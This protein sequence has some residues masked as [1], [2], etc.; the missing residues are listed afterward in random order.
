MRS[1]RGLPLSPGTPVSNTIR[2]SKFATRGPQC[3]SIPTFSSG[4]RVLGRCRALCPRA[5]AL[6]VPRAAAAENLG[7]RWA[8]ASCKFDIR[9]QGLVQEPQWCSKVLITWR[10][11]AP[12]TL[13]VAEDEAESHPPSLAYHLHYEKWWARTNQKHRPLQ[14]MMRGRSLRERKNDQRSQ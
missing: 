7:T 14:P 9:N 5:P 11:A 4:L 10:V 2:G 6:N 8:P 13:R 1:D 3:Q 12:K